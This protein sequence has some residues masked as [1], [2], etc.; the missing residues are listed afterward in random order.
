MIYKLKFYLAHRK[1]FRG[2][3]F[4]LWVL[5]LYL[6]FNYYFNLLV[7]WMF[8]NLII[9]KKMHDRNSRWHTLAKFTKEREHLIKASV[10][11]TDVH[12]VNTVVFPLFKCAYRKTHC[13]ASVMIVIAHGS[14]DKGLKLGS[15][16]VR[17]HMSRAVAC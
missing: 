6:F 10:F 17:C 13:F 16:I 4:L 11:C 5:Y 7:F 12:H 1:F 3:Q 8:Y 14:C 15:K 2:F 9:N